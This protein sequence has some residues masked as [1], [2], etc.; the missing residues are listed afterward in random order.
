MEIIISNTNVGALLKA[1]DSILKKYGRETVPENIKGQTVL[2]VIKTLST[3]G[4]FSICNL[5][6]LAEM[7]GVTFSTEH[8]D[9][10]RTLHCVDWKNIHP[11]TKEYTFALITDYFR[12]NIV[13]SNTQHETSS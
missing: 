9:F 12:G 7:A 10:F 11:E 8:Y 13:M 2:S 4:H 3:G 5:D 1:T 6:S